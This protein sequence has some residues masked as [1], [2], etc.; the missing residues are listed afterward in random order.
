M[1]SADHDE[2]RE[3]GAALRRA[4][5]QRNQHERERERREQ[6]RVVQVRIEWHELLGGLQAK[7]RDY[8]ARF[9]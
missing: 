9:P 1:P 2:H 4:H 7:R 6:Q 8:R 5:G 3:H